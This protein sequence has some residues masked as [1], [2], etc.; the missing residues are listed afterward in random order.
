MW[1]AA[2]ELHPAPEPKQFQCQR[3]LGGVRAGRLLPLLAVLLRQRGRVRGR[4]A[5]QAPLQ[6]QQRLRLQRGGGQGVGGPAGPRGEWRGRG[7]AQKQ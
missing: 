4:R 6:Q 7:G 2:R 1:H 3:D 5:A